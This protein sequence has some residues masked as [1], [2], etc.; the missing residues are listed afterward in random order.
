MSGTSASL[1]RSCGAKSDRK[2]PVSTPSK[3]KNCE[4]ESLIRGKDKNLST[5]ESALQ[6][7]HLFISFLK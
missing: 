7:N 4:F 6:N 5:E 3:I 1:R 2:I